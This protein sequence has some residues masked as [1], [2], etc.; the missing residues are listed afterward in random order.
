MNTDGH[1]FKTEEF[2]AN[3]ANFHEFLGKV[4]EHRRDA[5]TQRQ[6]LSAQSKAL[7]GLPG[8]S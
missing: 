2:D 7:S 6:D 1:R 4:K 8:A 5:E 3:C